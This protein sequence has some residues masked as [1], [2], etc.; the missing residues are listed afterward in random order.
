MQ[1]VERDGGLV[2][3]RRRRIHDLPGTPV[4]WEGSGGES[5]GQRRG[6]DRR[7]VTGRLDSAPASV[8]IFSGAFG[9]YGSRSGSFALSEGR[10]CSSTRLMS[11]TT[12]DG[13]NIN[14]KYRGGS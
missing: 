11:S 14:T 4:F 7:S 5:R 10:R 6:P 12:S 9:R 2:G 8:T 13:T 3:E 1:C